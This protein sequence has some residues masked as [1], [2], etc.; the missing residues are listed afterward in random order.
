MKSLVESENRTPM[1]S[2]PFL[3]SLAIAMALGLA[4]CKPS[5]TAPSTSSNSETAS[6]NPPAAT[7]SARPDFEKLKGKWTRPDG[8][9]VLEIRGVDAGGRMD[10]GYFNP[11]PIRVAQARA[12]REGGETKAFIE[13]R[14]MN[15]PGCTYKLVLDA[16]HD[17]LFGV[18]HQAAIQQTFD[19]VFTRVQ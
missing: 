7:Q 19:V 1:K 3:T 4:A 8:G 15:Y 18:Y 16:R 12:Y 2:S 17:Q 5:A 9:Y 13:L 14:D 11:S 6:T 10:A